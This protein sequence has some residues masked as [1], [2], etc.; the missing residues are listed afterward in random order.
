I[1]VGHAELLAAVPADK[2]DRALATILASGLDVAKTRELLMR[3]TQSLAAAAFDKGECT[4]CPFNSGTQRA[5]FETHVDDG[6]CT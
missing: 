2:Q 5:L 6:H 4:T 1:K 3:V